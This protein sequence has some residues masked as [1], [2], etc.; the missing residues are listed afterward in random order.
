MGRLDLAGPAAVRGR[1]AST[2]VGGRPFPHRAE[3][4]FVGYVFV[5]VMLVGPGLTA[6]ALARKGVETR[7]ADPVP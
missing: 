6:G 4:V 2:V 3:L 1:T 7:Q 5:V